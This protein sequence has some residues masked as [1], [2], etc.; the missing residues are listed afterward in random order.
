M[1]PN[2]TS[3]YVGET[4]VLS[5]VT[6]GLPL[7]T[8][9][10]TRDG[11]PLRSPFIVNETEIVSDHVTFLRS[12]L[13]LCALRVPDDGQYSC[14][15]SNNHSTVQQTFSLTV[16][17]TY[18]HLHLPHSVTIYFLLVHFFVAVEPQIVIFPNSSDFFA[19]ST[20][21]LTCAGYG[22]PLPSIQ[23]NRGSSDEL[24]RVSANDSRVDIWEKMVEVGGHTF[25]QSHLRIC[26]TVES[27]SGVYSCTARTAE[28]EDREEFEVNAVGVPPTLI[29]TPGTYSQQPSGL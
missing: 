18:S 21:L 6:Y 1:A 19:G 2:D 15:A 9:S 16:K 4:V 26:S 3:L 8:I 20:V 23:W 5:C 12:T 13:V 10:W 29:L 28:R 24:L 14:S 22:L 25:I 17:G 27:D 11:L 7:P